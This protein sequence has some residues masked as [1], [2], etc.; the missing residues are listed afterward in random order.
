M[1]RR[2]FGGS[3]EKDEV[4]IPTLETMIVGDMLDYDLKTWQ[5]VAFNTYDYEGDKTRE[6]EIKSGDE[7]RFL[8][9]GRDGSQVW[10][11]LTELV[12]TGQI[13]GDPVGAVRRG[14]D[15]PEEVILD[16]VLYRATECSTGLLYPDGKGPESEFVCWSYETDDGKMLALNQ[17]GEN[18][19][20]AY[21]GEY[22]EEYQFTDILPGSQEA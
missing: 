6:W 17:W 8:E 7:L 11:T 2:L 20:N 4:R 16:G 19:F 18:E 12:E 22:V 10:W 15:P 1:I 21:R 5:V 13:G 3:E 14:E 9:N